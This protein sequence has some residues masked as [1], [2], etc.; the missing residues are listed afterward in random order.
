[1]LAARDLVGHFRSYSEA[2]GVLLS[3]QIP[4]SAVK[5]IKDF[6]TCWWSTYSM[7]E[8]LFWL[9]SFLALMEAEGLLKKILTFLV[10][11]CQGYHYTFRAILMCSKI[12]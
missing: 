8:H 2:K 7:C 6:A 3:K 11:D 9:Q 1:M 4:G 5:C 12:T 10:A